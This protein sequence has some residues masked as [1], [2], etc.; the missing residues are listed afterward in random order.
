MMGQCTTLTLQHPGNSRASVC[1]S[2]EPFRWTL[3]MAI[4]SI[5]PITHART[6][7]YPWQYP[8][9]RLPHGSIQRTVS[10]KP[11]ADTHKNMSLVPLSRF[12]T[13]RRSTTVCRISAR[14]FHLP[15][16][17]LEQRTTRNQGPAGAKRT[18]QYSTVHRA[19]LSMHQRETTT[20]RAG[21]RPGYTFR[22]PRPV[23]QPDRCAAVLACISAWNDR[24]ASGTPKPG[25]LGASLNP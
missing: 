19:M 3:N 2:I 20:T 1:T 25:L 16:P 18:V 8:A 17:R 9:H 14:V 11:N 15:N 4:P 21:N 13:R 6:S 7:A 22:D 24:A 12:R 10:R 23:G 5:A